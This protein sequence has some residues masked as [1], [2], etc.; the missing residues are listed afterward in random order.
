MRQVARLTDHDPEF[1][2]VGDAREVV[3]QAETVTS[4]PKRERLCS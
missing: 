4:Q 2:D 1:G 3:D